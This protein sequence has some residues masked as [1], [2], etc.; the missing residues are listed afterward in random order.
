MIMQFLFAI[1]AR[2]KL[3]N[4]SLI[5]MDDISDSFDYQNKYAIV[6]YIKDLSEQYSDNP[7]RPSCRS[8]PSRSLS[9]PAGAGS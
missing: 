3:D 2:K 7:G 9:C 1:E 8:A 5:V 6:E 4:M